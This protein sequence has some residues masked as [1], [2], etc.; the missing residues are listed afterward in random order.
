MHMSEQGKV[1]KKLELIG[2]SYSTRVTRNVLTT[3]R[4]ASAVSTL[5]ASTTVPKC[6]H[7]IHLVY[8]KAP[9]F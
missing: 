5:I 3:L 9:K 6:A 1:G 2:M 7:N 4:P 8:C